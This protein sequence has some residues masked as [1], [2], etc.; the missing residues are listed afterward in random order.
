MARLVARVINVALTLGVIAVFTLGIAGPFSHRIPAALAQISTH[1]R[2][3]TTLGTTTP[4]TTVRSV[5]T[6]TRVTPT[7]RPPVTRTVVSVPRVTLPLVTLPP[8]TVAT[9]S[10]TSTTI[11]A[12]GTKLPRVAATLPLTTKGTNAHVNPVFAM[13]SGAGFFLALVIIVGRF[14]ASRP[15]RTNAGANSAP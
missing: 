1:R 2:S 15:K 13:L 5:P 7:T 3:T 4:P 12:I 10:T 9:T 6:T 8:R 11:A 14:L